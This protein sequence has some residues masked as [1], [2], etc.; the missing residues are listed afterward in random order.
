MAYWVEKTYPSKREEGDFT[1]LLLSPTMDARGADIYKN[2]REISPGD[3]V[4]H[5]NQDSNMLIGY[6]ECISNYEIITTKE[7]VECYTVNL[8]NFKAFQ[9][10]INIDYVLSHENNLNELN[11]IKDSG[12]E[13]FF[14]KRENRFYIRQG[15]Y[16]TK[17]SNELKNLLTTET[18]SISTP[19][20]IDI[21]NE[22]QLYSEGME[23]FVIHKKKERSKRLIKDAKQKFKDNNNGKLFCECCGFN[24]NDV[25]GDLGND[26]IE[27]HHITPISSITSDHR[28]SIEDIA[29]LC[30]NC[31]RMVHREPNLDL[32][33]IKILF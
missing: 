10:A 13:T 19:N 11:R 27:G 24:F 23:K 1:E 21:I 20:D 31:H 32:N 12:Q 33:N 8:S 18:I 9:P 15:G 25:Y 3:I 26:F 5:I 17:L 6:S 22:S 16:L 28:S 14:Q 4:F 7:D 2:M 30:S 29:L